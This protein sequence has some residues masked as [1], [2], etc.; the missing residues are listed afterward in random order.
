MTIVVRKV[1][2]LATVQDAGRTG[3]ASHAVPRGGALVRDRMCAANAAIG[4]DEHA[5]CVEIFGRL[6]IAA[7]RDI[8]LATEDGAFALRAGEERAID[9]R[10]DAR[11]RYL[12]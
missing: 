12:A 4:N 9:P 1:V 2:G 8:D 3:C 5:A 6:V 10:A 7:E 11:V